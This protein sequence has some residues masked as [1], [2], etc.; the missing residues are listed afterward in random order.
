MSEWFYITVAKEKDEKEQ[1]VS[2]NHQKPL[3][4]FNDDGFTVL[5]V[6][7]IVDVYELEEADETEDGL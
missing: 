6:V 7:P 2:R 3:V 4:F 1:D 5:D